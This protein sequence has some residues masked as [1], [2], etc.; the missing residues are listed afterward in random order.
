M[1]IIIKIDIYFTNMRMIAFLAATL[2]AT[3]SG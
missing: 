1:G 2:A 3:V